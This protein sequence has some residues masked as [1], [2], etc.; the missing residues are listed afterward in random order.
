MR[1][2]ARVRVWM[3]MGLRDGV[4]GERVMVLWH[5]RVGK[6]VLMLGL[7]RMLVLMQVVVCQATPQSLCGELDLPSFSSLPWVLW[8]CHHLV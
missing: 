3:G 6:S 2:C 1:V 5:V 4:G 8:D 7:M